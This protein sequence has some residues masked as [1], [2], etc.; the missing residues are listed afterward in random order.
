MGVEDRLERAAEV[1]GKYAV[2]ITRF[3]TGL[4]GPSDAADVVSAAV[5]GCLS[6]G[7]W[8]AVDDPRAYLYRSVLNQARMTHRGSLRRAA[9]ELR[10]AG[11]EELVVPEKLPEVLAAV[12]RLS[13][14][15][16]AVIM[17]TYWDDLDPG[18]I[19][20]VLGISE[21]SVRRHLAR[22]RA[23]LRELL[24]DRSD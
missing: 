14:R 20:A 12:A 24:H 10:T 23:R 2:E 1:Y 11:P 22:A 7:R 3:A 21:G 13:L 6:S 15:Q 19:A 17:L 5:L 16:R 8:P 4:V 18:A 9:R